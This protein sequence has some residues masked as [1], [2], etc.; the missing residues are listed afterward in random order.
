MCAAAIDSLSNEDGTGASSAVLERARAIPRHHPMSPVA[1]D[2]DAIFVAC[3]VFLFAVM[4]FVFEASSF[5]PRPVRWLEGVYRA[6]FGFLYKP[7]SKS[8]FL[9]FIGFLQFGLDS[10]KGNAMGLACGILTI[11]AGVGLTL[12]YCKE[13][14]HF[15]TPGEKYTPPVIP[16]PVPPAP[17]SQE[18]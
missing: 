7:V 13:P 14:A 6:N 11:A 2:T 5:S 17:S 1:E 16:P 12:V 9:I 15:N 10:S 18:V 8:V 3:Y 4:L